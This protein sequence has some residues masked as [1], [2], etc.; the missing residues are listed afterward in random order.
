MFSLL[1]ILSGVGLKTQQK[2]W[3]AVTHDKTSF[4][5]IGKHR[6]VACWECHPKGVMK[7]TPTDCEA[8]H[9][10]R[11]QDDRYQLQLGVHCEECHTPIDWKK[12]KS[13]SWS[14]EQDA[15]FLLEGIH[16]TIDCFRCHKGSAFTGQVGDCIDCHREDYN[17]ADEPNHVL[18]QFPE[19]CK[20]CHNSI[21][22]KGAVYS[23]LFFPLNGMHKTAECTG[24]HQNNQYPGTPTDC[25]ACHQALY[26]NTTSPSHIEAGY[27]PYCEVCHGNSALDWY[28]AKFDHGRVWALKGAHRGLD[29][30]VCHS[31]GYNISSDC[32]NCHL[33]DYNNTSDPDHRKAGFHTACE[34]C[35]LT[36]ALTW[37]QAVFQHNF[38]I[39]S[40]AHQNAFCSDCHK[41]TNYFEFSCIDC[42]AH[43][44]TEM[45]NKHNNVG[46]YTYNSQA[47][48]SCHPTGEK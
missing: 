21:D 23:H 25:F 19:D 29:C 6:T 34:V 3:N 41:T 27:P 28:G 18:A 42:H 15:G 47:C 31:I 10:Y 17:K 14:H 46:G 16:R 45:D 20:I 43:I 30:N 5:L 37:S 22:W 40:G 44:K 7:G 39:F 13:G 24:C 2:H 26:N 38:P 12:I 35:H 4:P 32:I 9:W 48:Y 33:D 1:F 36:E 11:K 8:C